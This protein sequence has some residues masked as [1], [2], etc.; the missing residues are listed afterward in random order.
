MVGLAFVAM[1]TAS[2]LVEGGW[3][4]YG[5]F[6]FFLFITGLTQCFAYIEAFVTNVCDQTKHNRI[7]VSFA[8]CFI[9][10]GLSTV[11]T[12]NVGWVLHD[13][14]EHYTTNYIV[15]SVGLLQC[16]AVGWFFEYETTAA[17]SELHR[18]SLKVLT[19]MYWVPVVVVCFYANFAFNSLQYIGLGIISVTSVVAL[20]ASYKVSQMPFNSW[21]HEIAMQGVDKLSMS[22]TSLS[23][24][25]SKRADWMPL[26]ETYFGFS[27]KYINPACLFYILMYNLRGD[28]WTPYSDQGQDM[29]IISTIYLLIA[30]LIVVIP[31]FACS[32]PEMFT[33]NVNLEFIADHMYEI[34]LRMAREMKKKF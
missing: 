15:I 12:S 28:L 4:G 8:V 10:L 11:Y 24:P 32:Y 6:L 2:S 1:P 26:F 14:T 21:Y 16:V 9:G 13:M 20:I 18:K 22:I 5:L 17:V 3:M 34:R 25:D 23:Y 33:H 19:L 7:A 27:I 29:Q 30:V 31:L